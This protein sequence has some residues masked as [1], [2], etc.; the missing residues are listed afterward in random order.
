[1]GVP[2][3]DIRV[4]VT[5]DTAAVGASVITASTGNFTVVNARV[6]T[7]NTSGVFT[8]DVICEGGDDDTPV[9]ITMDGNQGLTS[10]TLLHGC[11]LTHSLN[12]TSPLNITVTGNVYI[13]AFSQIN[14]D[15]KGHLGALT[16]FNT[17][18]NGGGAGGGIGAGCFGCPSSGGGGSYG[19][20]GA[21][22]GVGSAGTGGSIHGDYT[23]P[24]NMGSGGGGHSSGLSQPDAGHG[25]GLIIMSV[26]GTFQNEGIVT[27]NG[28]DGQSFSGGGSGGGINITAANLTGS[29]TF[30]AN[31]GSSS[32][33]DGPSGGGGR[34]A[35]K[36]TSGTVSNS[37]TYE[38]YSFTDSG[39][40]IG[41]AGTIYV[42]SGAADPGQLIIDND[43][44]VPQV[45]IQDVS[46][47]VA[48]V[49]TIGEVIVRNKAMLA[50][51][52]DWTADS[53]TVDGG[54]LLAS[55]SEQFTVGVVNVVNG[56]NL[57]ARDRDSTVNYN[58]NI[59]ADEMTIDATS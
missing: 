46:T 26:D 12:A 20:K 44:N 3:N 48:G 14:L 43:G 23:N 16:T 34:I 29:G 5:A 7:S 2:D 1:S 58:L 17:G 21:N 11:I 15:E 49:Q 24:I 51:S 59:S 10:L 4:R 36:S 22:G 56:G 13:D 55:T 50:Y 41:G 38:A 27:A 6:I 31:G 53:L 52:D 18:H 28:Q 45:A 39:G 35:L 19:G 57:T 37:Y 42:R 47:L 32:G 8:G 25:G 9:V 30:R 33:V 54:I 40:E